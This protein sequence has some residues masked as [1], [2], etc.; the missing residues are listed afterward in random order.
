MNSGKA[1]DYVWPKKPFFFSLFVLNSQNQ[2]SVSID[3]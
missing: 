2:T 1:A 3:I